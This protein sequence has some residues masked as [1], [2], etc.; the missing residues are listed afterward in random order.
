[1]LFKR[2]KSFWVR[3]LRVWV[4]L[5]WWTL[6]FAALKEIKWRQELGYLRPINLGF[7]SFISSI[8]SVVQLLS[9]VQL[10]VTL[11]SAAHQ[12]SLSF[13]IFWSLLKLTSIGSVMLSNHLSSVSPSS[14]CLQSFPSSGSFPMSWL[15]ASRGQSIGASLQHQS[16]QWIFRVD[17]L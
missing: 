5:K 8:C 9:H 11:W 4:W 12:A 14:F 6:G 17:Y 10:F 7:F 15:S 13:T 16:F 1:M 3:H 2:T